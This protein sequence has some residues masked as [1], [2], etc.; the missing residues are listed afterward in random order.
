MSAP[1]SVPATVPE[2]WMVK[3]LSVFTVEQLEQ[4]AEL[5]SMMRDLAVLRR[6]EQSLTVLFNDKGLPRYFNGTNNVPAVKPSTYVE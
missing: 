4:L 2:R 3:M 5:A 1:I 6:C